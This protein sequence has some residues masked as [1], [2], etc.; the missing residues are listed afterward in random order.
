M[1]KK[2]KIMV[3]DDH[4]VFRQCLVDTLSE[5]NDL[6]VIG[7][8]A[9]GREILK[10][11]RMN[12]PDVIV[13]DIE[14]PE[15]NGFALAKSLKLDYPDIKLIFLSMYYSPSYAAQAIKDGVNSCLPKECSIDTLIEAIRTVFLT[16]Y[17]FKND[18]AFS[19]I[20]DLLA[21]KTF[22]QL[23]QQIQLN[24]R[25]AEVL[26]LLCEGK[27]NREIAE[28]LKLSPATIDFHRQSIYKKTD[29]SSI[30]LLVKY[31]IKNGLTTLN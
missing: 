26:K 19:V 1:P 21:E 10:Q 3:A 28:F 31:A 18:V 14:M 6:R 11:V 12:K 27:Q 7:H 24:H 2:I 13:T 16:G 17:Y 29:I 25:E 23:K 8:G 5:C 22:E 4:T 9:N 15:V 20:S 30:A